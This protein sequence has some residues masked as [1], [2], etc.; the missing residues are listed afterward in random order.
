MLITAIKQ[1]SHKLET[2]PSLVLLYETFHE[3]SPKGDMNL[4]YESHLYYF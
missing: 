1:D 3:L 4:F 2:I